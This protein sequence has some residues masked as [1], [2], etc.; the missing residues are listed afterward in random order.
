M[1]PILLRPWQSKLV[2]LTT[3]PLTLF[4]AYTW[5]LNTI[6]DPPAVVEGHERKV[7]YAQGLITKEEFKNPRLLAARR[8]REDQERK[9]QEKQDNKWDALRRE[10]KETERE[11]R[12]RFPTAP[13]HP[14][15]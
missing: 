3:G 9:K 14:G 2:L 4:F 7:A 10:E 6:P 15:S 11:W 1:F 8:A 13:R 12:E 5:L